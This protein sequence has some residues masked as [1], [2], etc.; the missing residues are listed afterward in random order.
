MTDPTAISDGRS[1]RI[2]CQARPWLQT[3][4]PDDFTA[5]LAETAGEIAVARYT[6]FETALARLPLDD[7]KGFSDILATAG[8]IT[9]CGAH[10]GGRWWASDVTD[11]IESLASRAAL[12]PAV[13][14]DQLVVSLQATPEN[15]TDQHLVHIADNLARLGQACRAA[16]G[17]K[18]AFHNHAGEL[19]DNAR[20]LTAIVDR[21]DPDDVQLAAD[22]GWVAY[23]G[24][25]V[26]E[27]IRRFGTRLGYLHVRDI[28]R[29]NEFIEVGRGVLDYPQILDALTAVGYSGWLV[30]ESEFSDTW[31]GEQTP[32]ETV[33]AQIQGLLRLL[34]AP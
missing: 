29:N 13:G 34:Q 21:C 18:V 1:W 22:I 10:A 3:L 23:A 8:G 5:R 15:P 28:T 9:L 33:N 20:I 11:D 7:P 17:V 16:A 14:C 27:F 24:V 19:A 6:G 2:G 26:A 4:S 30:V 31:Q 12:L 25:D 32:K